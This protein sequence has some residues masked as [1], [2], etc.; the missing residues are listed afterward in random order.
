MLKWTSGL[1]AASLSVG[2][3]IV[4]AQAAWASGVE[5]APGDDRLSIEASVA[6]EV[7]AGSPADVTAYALLSGV[8]AGYERRTA[9]DP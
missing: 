6:P 7:L 8:R 3:A 5:A 1:V 9:T 4:P 2:A